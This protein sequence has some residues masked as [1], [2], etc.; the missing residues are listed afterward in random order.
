MTVDQIA[1][2]FH[3]DMMTNRYL[4]EEVQKNFDSIFNL[5]YDQALIRF[6]KIHN[7]LKTKKQTLYRDGGRSNN[8][9]SVTG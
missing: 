5:T 6:R 3:M 1:I 8:N 7:I 2:L 9:K 4:K